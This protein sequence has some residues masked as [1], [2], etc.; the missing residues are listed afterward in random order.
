MAIDDPLRDAGILDMPAPYTPGPPPAGSGGGT[1][2]TGYSG[3]QGGVGSPSGG[4]GG[5]RPFDWQGL[6]NWD[7]RTSG[8][9]DQ[10]VSEIQGFSPVGSEFG[11]ML[12]KLFS[13][14]QGF[15]PELLAR[16]KTQAAEMNAGSTQN[17]LQ[18]QAGRDNATGFGKSAAS[19]YAQSQIRGQG[20]QNLQRNLTELDVQNA[21]MGL[22][23]QLGTGGLLANLYG[24]E[25]GLKGQLANMY[26]NRQAPM[27]PGSWTQGSNAGSAGSPWWSQGGQYQT[28]QQPHDPFYQPPQQGTGGQGYTPQNP[29]SPW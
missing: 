24:Q 20:A 5:P 22:Q 13:G 11:Q 25:S 2:S 7:D 12:M 16:L 15:T 27:Y 6:Q 1:W 18:R 3:T 19:N 8:Y 14:G 10:G 17:T 29:W 9:F 4:G 23:R 21:L 26:A 28:G